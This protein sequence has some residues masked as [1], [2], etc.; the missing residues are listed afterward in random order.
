VSSY[1]ESAGP[2]T[3]GVRA[4]R[5]I[6]DD[7]PGAASRTTLGRGLAEAAVRLER[8]AAAG[9]CATTTS[10]ALRAAAD[11][12]RRIESHLHLERLEN[13]DRDLELV[14]RRLGTIEVPQDYS[15]ALHQVHSRLDALREIRTSACL[16]RGE[17]LPAEP[18]R[19]K[20]DISSR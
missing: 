7:S 3:E 5:S 19:H 14:G 9:T 18:S 13:L 2:G 4:V 6:P 8:L 15:R 11:D 17:V 12:L 1:P 10:T 16:D 20:S